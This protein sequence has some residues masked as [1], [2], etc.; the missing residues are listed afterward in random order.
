M[1]RYDQMKNNKELAWE[2]IHENNELF[3]PYFFKF[4]LSNKIILR[5]E[6][7]EKENISMRELKVKTDEYTFRYHLSIQ[8]SCLRFVTSQGPRE[9]ADEIAKQL[10]TTMKQDQVIEWMNKNQVIFNSGFKKVKNI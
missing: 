10:P 4:F 7:Q 9:L 8:L 3:N 2:R 1:I 6:I 5:L